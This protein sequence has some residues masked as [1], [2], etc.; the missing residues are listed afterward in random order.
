MTDPIFINHTAILVPDLQC[1]QKRGLIH[2]SIVEIPN[3]VPSTPWLWHILSM[4]LQLFLELPATLIRGKDR[5]S[6]K[7]CD[8][9]QECSFIPLHNSRWTYRLNY[10]P[11]PPCSSLSKLQQSIRHQPL[12]RWDS[13]MVLWMH[14]VTVLGFIYSWWSEM[15]VLDNLCYLKRPTNWLTNQLTNQL[16]D[17]TNQPTN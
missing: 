11:R 13:A 7:S 16:T 12:R 14:W 17:Q 8:C 10:P 15:S 1:S 3:I 2:F 6:L 5:L 4:S 9:A